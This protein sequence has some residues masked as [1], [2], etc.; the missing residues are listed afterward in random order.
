M[1]IALPKISRPDKLRGV[2]SPAHRRFFPL[3]AWLLLCAWLCGLLVPAR[4]EAMTT[5]PAK[6]ASW[7]AGVSASGRLSDPSS[8]NQDGIRV[9]EPC[10]YESVSGLPE[11]LSR[12]PIAENGGINL[13]EYSGNSPVYRIDPLGLYPATLGLSGRQTNALD[14]PNYPTPSAANVAEAAGVAAIGLP[15]IG[16]ASE[17]MLGGTLANAVGDATL[18]LAA[19]FSGAATALA[20]L[21]AALGGTGEELP[22]NQVL[23]CRWGRPG[24]QPG[25][26]VMKGGKNF[27]NYFWSGKYQPSWMPGG[28][29]PASPASGEE[30]LVPAA[31]IVFPP[32]VVGAIKAMLGQRIYT[33]PE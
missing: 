28:N 12:D 19:R 13:Y 14:N 30:F 4:V 2:S 16:V 33:G 29:I 32:G 26:W 25:D 5:A 7:G 3:A 17:A 21:A 8:V 11:W 18:S 1:K 24:L 20:G 9:G 15:A 10:D 31:S 23:V 6:I 22:E 27:W